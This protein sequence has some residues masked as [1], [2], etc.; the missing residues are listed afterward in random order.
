M[1]MLWRLKQKKILKKNQKKKRFQMN[2]FYTKKIIKYSKRSIDISDVQ[3]ACGFLRCREE[4]GKT[5]VNCKPKSRFK[6]CGICEKFVCQDETVCPNCGHT[7][8]KYM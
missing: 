5:E 4:D 2:V 7:F 3:K 6:K 1:D 8:A